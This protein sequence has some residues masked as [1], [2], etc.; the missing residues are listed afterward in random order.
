[1]IYELL[2][3]LIAT[4]VYYDL[5]YVNSHVPLSIAVTFLTLIYTDRY[6]L[7][8]ISFLISFI[9]YE[10]MTVII[11]RQFIDR[12]DY[13]HIANSVTLLQ[14]INHLPLFL[15]LYVVMIAIS[16]FIYKDRI[17]TVAQLYL[18]TFFISV[19]LADSAP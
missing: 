1:M 3:L 13:L 11:R 6:S 19:A 2:L 16:G 15:S 5:R 14:N 17:P 18:S 7:W 12:S 10:T 8:L 4:L 9:I